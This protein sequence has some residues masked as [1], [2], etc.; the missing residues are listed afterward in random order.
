M[1]KELQITRTPGRVVRRVY[2]LTTVEGAS[3]PV[4]DIDGEFAY[5][6]VGEGHTSGTDRVSIHRNGGMAPSAPSVSGIGLVER[7]K[8]GYEA[9]AT[10]MKEGGR[11]DDVVG[12]IVDALKQ[13]S[14][15]R[16][17]YKAITSRTGR[18]A[19]VAVSADEVDANTV[20]EGS[21]DLSDRV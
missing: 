4:L 15:S 19:M 7:V 1:V 14:A 11:T 6:V 16:D 3:K 18:K 20:Q 10:A 17:H 8:I 12:A 5:S 9:A 21:L 2:T 13:Y